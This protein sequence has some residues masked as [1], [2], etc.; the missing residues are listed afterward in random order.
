M[1]HHTHSE[2]YQQQKKKRQTN[3]TTTLEELEIRLG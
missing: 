2:P 1:N 3:H